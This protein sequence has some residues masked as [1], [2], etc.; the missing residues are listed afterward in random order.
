MEDLQLEIKNK[1]QKLYQSLPDED[2]IC[3]GCFF[4]EVKPP[5]RGILPTNIDVWRD[6]YTCVCNHFNKAWT[7]A[8]KNNISRLMECLVFGE[9]VEI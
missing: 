2:R 8:N 7:T 9:K 5:L 4:L 1:F 6:R 3:N